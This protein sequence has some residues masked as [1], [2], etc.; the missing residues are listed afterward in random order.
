[1]THGMSILNKLDIIIELEFLRVVKG[2]EKGYCPIC[3]RVFELPFRTH[4]YLTHFQ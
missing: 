1:M 3:K 2:Y 4:Y